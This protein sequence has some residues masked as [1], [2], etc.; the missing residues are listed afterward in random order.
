MIVTLIDIVVK[1][2]FPSSGGERWAVAMR[3]N[4]RAY[5]SV[6]NYET[7]PEAVARA[8]SLQDQAKA[9]GYKVTLQVMK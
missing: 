1:P 8:N 7:K 6:G 9:K 2:Y 3:K 4:G 5:E